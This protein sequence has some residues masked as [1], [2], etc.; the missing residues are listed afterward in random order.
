V[1]QQLAPPGSVVISAATHQQIAGSFETRDLGEVPV[2]GR[3]PARAFEVLRPRGPRTR[4][5]VAVEQG[6]QAF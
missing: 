6:M 3:A 4:L 1:S 2:K 5:E